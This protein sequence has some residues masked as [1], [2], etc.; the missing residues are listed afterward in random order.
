MTDK[1]KNKGS[2]LTKK[3]EQF[4][5]EYIIDLNATQAAIR[6]GYSKKTARIQASQNLA[7]VN[8]QQYLQTL[9]DKRS[10][11]LEL[12]AENVLKEIS[13]LAFSNI[14]R[15]YDENGNLMPVNKLDNDVSAS[16]QEVTQDEI[17]ESVTKRKYKLADKRASLEL[18]GRHLKLFT[19][20][21]DLGGGT[22]VNIIKK[23]FDGTK[24]EETD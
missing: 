6:A 14:N 23:R 8:I 22:T 15:L 4:C 10:K 12:T 16:I 20:K 3:Q 1:P 11:K 9:M 2:G 21:V 17:G 18:L 7:K 24:E 13:K 5:K 19:D